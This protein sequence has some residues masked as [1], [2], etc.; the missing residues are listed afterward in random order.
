MKG[1]T[2]KVLDKKIMADG[3]EALQIQ[4]LTKTK[5]SNINPSEAYWI[6]KGNDRHFVLQG[7]SKKTEALAL[8]P[9]EECV[10]CEKM[11]KDDHNKENISKI[12]RKIKEQNNVVDAGMF[13]V[14]GGS[15]DLPENG[16]PQP[17]TEVAS[18]QE[19][20]QTPEQVSL[21]EK[22]K[23]YSE[24][25][26]VKAMISKANKQARSK[27]KRDCYKFVKRALMAKDEKNNSLVSTYLPGG[28]T[29][30]AEKYMKEN[31]FTNLL[32]VEPYKSEIK[33]PQQAPKGAILIYEGGSACLGGAVPNCGHIEIKAN[34]GS[35]PGYIYD[36]KVDQPRVDAPGVGQRYK[37]KG[38]MVKI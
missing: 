20:A 27:S 36:V 25:S 23:K 2:F 29:R 3:S 12:T 24:S 38:V 16:G 8:L 33:K 6:Y 7:H 32:D 30:V 10:D 34:E 13:E 11:K 5:Y 22:I 19:V 15:I 4:P 9:N 37:L 26:E 14:D 18:V 1:S 28:T 17:A 31:G 35:T 21:E